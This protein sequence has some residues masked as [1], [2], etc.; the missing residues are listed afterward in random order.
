MKKMHPG[1]LVLLITCIAAVICPASAYVILSADVCDSQDPVMA[2]SPFSYTI[3]YTF[4]TMGSGSATI[5][6]QLPPEVSF[7]SASGGGMYDS[8]TH[9][10]RWDVGQTFGSSVSV[11]VMPDH[12]LIPD[13]MV[14]VPPLVIQNTATISWNTDSVPDLE[15]T[16]ILMPEPICSPE[17]PSML[18]PASLITGVGA[19]LLIRITRDH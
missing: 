1:L 4:N 16:T 7:V 10:V 6:D 3:D 8:A 19:V 15:S 5:L 18:L 11:T 2:F 17:F 12:V 14:Q 9:S 13:C